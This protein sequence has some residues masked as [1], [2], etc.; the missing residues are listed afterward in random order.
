MSLAFYLDHHVPA[1]IADGLRQL[2]VDVLT[3]AEDGNADWDDER[4]LERALDLSGLSSPRIGIFS[5]SRPAGSSPD[6][7]LP[8]WSTAINFGSRSVEPCETSPSLRR[9]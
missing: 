3:V 2:Q 4:L 9:L 5:F 7:S 1:A 6:V 8:A